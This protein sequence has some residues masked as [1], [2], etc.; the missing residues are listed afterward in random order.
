MTQ[1]KSLDE[2]TDEEVDS[3][4]EEEYQAYLNQDGLTPEDLAAQ[5]LEEQDDPE[6]LATIQALE[7]AELPSG[8][9]LA[10]LTGTS[11]P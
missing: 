2:M 6:D 8:A 7:G 4:S 1:P 9:L 3:L 10:R 5:A 11:T